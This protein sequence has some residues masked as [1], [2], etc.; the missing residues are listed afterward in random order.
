MQIPFYLD[1]E[2]FF[3]L[4]HL[5]SL[6][7]LSLTTLMFQTWVLTV[8]LGEICWCL[9]L[10]THHMASPL[11]HW[12]PLFHPTYSHNNL[13][14]NQ[15]NCHHFLDFLRSKK[16]RITMRVP[17]HQ[18]SCLF[19]CDSFNY[20]IEVADNWYLPDREII[21]KLINNSN[22]RRNTERCRLQISQ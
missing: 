4:N 11:L 6:K 17:E 20:V 3:S 19:I 18:P 22:Y 9:S 21:K 12:M 13:W 7:L 8:R 5:N 16:K 2:W 14:V 1:T 10:N 15:Y